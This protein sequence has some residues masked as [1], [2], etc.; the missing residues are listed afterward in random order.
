MAVYVWVINK[1]SVGILVQQKISDHIHLKSSTTSTL[2]HC[3][4]L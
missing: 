3:M 4:W 2:N 1:Y